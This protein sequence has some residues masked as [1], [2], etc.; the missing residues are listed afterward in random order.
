M[1]GQRRVNELSGSSVFDSEYPGWAR[2]CK[3]LSVS[4]RHR[5]FNKRMDTFELRGVGH[6][7]GFGT[8]LFEAIDVGLLRR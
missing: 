8:L 6:L 3:K 2:S 5:S 1:S 7:L 4:F